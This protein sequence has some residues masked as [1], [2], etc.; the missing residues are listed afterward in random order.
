MSIRKKN[1][2]SLVICSKRRFPITKKCFALEAHSHEEK[3]VAGDC[4]WHIMKKNGEKRMSAEQKKRLIQ[5]MKP[6]TE[7]FAIGMV[8][9][10]LHEMTG[11]A[12]PCPIKLITGKYCPGCGITRMLFALLHFD[13]QAA[14]L[15]NRLLFFLLPVI[16]IY[17]VVKAAI[18]VVTGKNRQTLPEQIAV[19]LITILTIAFWVMRN[20]EAFSFLQPVG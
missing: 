19:V 3:I 14:F 18:F 20:M 2:R 1:K 7:V 13:F 4:T 11:L 5:I 8:Y 10:I 16:I 6:V 9:I 12:I 17:A 15:A